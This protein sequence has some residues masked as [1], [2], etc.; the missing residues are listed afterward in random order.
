MSW[1][2]RLLPASFRGIPFFIDSHEL[3]GGRHAVN[4]EQPDRQSPFSEDIGRRAN[5]FK[6]EA[7]VLGDNYFFLRDALIAAME[8]RGSGVLVHPY[9][10]IKNVQAAGYTVVED[11]TDGRIARFSL[12]FNE[13]GSKS[14]PFAQIDLVV[15]FATKA[16][17]TVAAIENAFELAYKVSQ[18][19]AFAQ[20]SAVQLVEDFADTFDRLF[21]NVR[22]LSS[23]HAELKKKIQE[24]KSNSASL[25]DSPAELFSQTDVV[26]DGLRELVPDPPENSTIDSTSGRDD[27]LAVFNDL[28][29]FRGEADEIPETTP[30]R[31]QERANA[32]AFADVIQQLAIVRLAQ[33]TVDK[34][35]KTNQDAVDQRTELSE[36]I[37]GQ[38]DKERTDDEVFQ[39]FEDLNG[40]LVA[41]VP[42][43]S[44]EFA[45]TREINLPVSEPSLVTTYNLYENLE[46]EQDLIDRNRIRNPVF[47]LGDLEVLTA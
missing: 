3:R 46:N 23:K 40:A 39:A 14:F 7:H 10:G 25:V 18:L 21:P 15:D 45:N 28:I 12:E 36:S 33:Q 44:S 26:I 8:T 20:E 27:K 35:F 37:Q 13:A 41:T 29:V 4:H 19:P 43:T 2:A 17:A 5:Q 22:T 42:D 32:D 31:T 34:E 38:L 6:I 11:T 1:T 9:L 47:A 30:T 16:V 24:Y